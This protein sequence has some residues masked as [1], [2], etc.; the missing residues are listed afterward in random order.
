MSKVIGFPPD[1]P[2]KDDGQ[3][4]L[5]DPFDPSRLR[6]S[7]RF[8]EAQDVRRIIVSVPVRKPH[9]QEFFRTHPDLEMWFEAAIL[10]LK[11]KRQLYLVEPGLVPLLAG[12]VVPKVLVPAITLQGALFLWH[13]KLEDER[14]RLDEWNAVALEAAERAKTKWIRLIANLEAGTYDL[15]EARGVLPEPEWPDLPLNRILALAFKDKII[16]SLDHPE[17]KTLRG[18]V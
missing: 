1:E 17:L 14:G 8:G 4:S 16:D 18:E 13:I 7:Q 12:E 11:E 15:W 2:P 3:S 10:D 6:L 5:A 9:K